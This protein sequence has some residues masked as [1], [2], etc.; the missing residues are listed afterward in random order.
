MAAMG[1]RSLKPSKPQ[2]KEKRLLG[3]LPSAIATYNVNG[4]MPREVEI[5]ELLD[6]ES[7]AVLVVQETL[8]TAQHYPLQV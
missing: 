5:R 6:E 2:T 1:E 3:H 8:V 7:V 4:Y